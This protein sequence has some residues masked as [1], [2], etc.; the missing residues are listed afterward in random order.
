MFGF[1]EGG[2]GW[3]WRHAVLSC[4]GP[5]LAWLLLA[6]YHNNGGTQTIPPPQSLFPWKR[7]FFAADGWDMLPHLGLIGPP[8]SGGV[9]SLGTGSTADG[10]T[11]D[12]SS[13]SSYT[14][15]PCAVGEARAYPFSFQRSR[16]PTRNSR[17]TATENRI[18][19]RIVATIPP[20][21][22]IESWSFPANFDVQRSDD[23]TQIVATLHEGESATKVTGS[24]K[25]RFISEMESGAFSH[26]DFQVVTPDSNKGDAGRYQLRYNTRVQ[27]P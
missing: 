18:P 2:I 10:I 9:T 15:A 19:L 4:L 22:L 14:T 27:R 11:Q 3:T 8:S 20:N 1:S 12:G 13:S 26:V 17:G 24:V 21:A 6:Q 23:G 5:F 16:V 7:C 25:L